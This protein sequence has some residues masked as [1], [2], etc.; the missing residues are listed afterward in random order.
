ME[1]H[2]KKENVW[3]KGP[4]W[5]TSINFDDSWKKII[6]YFILQNHKNHWSTR[7]NEISYCQ[8]D[9]EK[10]KEGAIRGREEKKTKNT[11]K[12]RTKCTNPVQK[13]QDRWPA[14]RKPNKNNPKSKSKR[15]EKSI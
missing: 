15:K 3:N 11:K 13:S 8:M 4:K 10:W 1:V 5:N 14:N 7:V 9:A 12:T 2:W 6:Q